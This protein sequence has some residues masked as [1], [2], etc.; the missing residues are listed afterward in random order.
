MPSIVTV[1]HKEIKRWAQVHGAVPA[2]CLWMHHDGEPPM[3]E[4][5]FPEHRRYDATLK[6]IP[7][8]DFFASFDL[9]EL[10]LMYELYDDSSGSTRANQLVHR[11]ASATGAASEE[12]ADA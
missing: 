7:W 4:F 10:A 5:I 9:M 1:D 11:R 6:P 12:A 8:E 3:L 2:Q